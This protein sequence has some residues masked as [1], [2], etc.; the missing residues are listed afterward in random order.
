MTTHNERTSQPTAV[1]TAN[2]DDPTWTRL[3]EQRKWYSS[4]STRNQRWYTWLKLIEIAIA[5]ILPVVSA[6]KSPIWI[7]GGLAAF[8]VVLEGA[9]QLFQFQPHWIMYRSTAE[10]LKHE[11]FLY[12]AGAGPYTDSDR[13]RK[14]AERIEGLISQEHAKWTSAHEGQTSHGGQGK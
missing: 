10:A 6:V 11:R 5:A 14:L 9:Q 7:T 3:E 4:R 12:L 1:P 8:I 13:H 2:E